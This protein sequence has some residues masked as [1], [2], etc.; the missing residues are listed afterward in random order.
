MTNYEKCTQA[1]NNLR[2]VM[3]NDQAYAHAFGYVSGMLTDE[4][5]DQF[6]AHSERKADLV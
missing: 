1:M 4:Q 3:P 6:L 5:I 2:E